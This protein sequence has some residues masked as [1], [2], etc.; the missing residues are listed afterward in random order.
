MHGRECCPELVQP[1]STPIQSGL[2][3]VYASALES[4]ECRACRFPSTTPQLA[5]RRVR[6]NNA[7]ITCSDANDSLIR[8]LGH[9]VERLSLVAIHFLNVRGCREDHYLPKERVSKK[10]GRIPAHLRRFEAKVE[11]PP[12]LEVIDALAETLPGLDSSGKRDIRNAVKD[13]RSKNCRPNCLMVLYLNR[14]AALD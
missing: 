14:G 9:P 8:I 1:E 5:D 7:G 12:W 13:V 4:C 2:F 11:G 6:T 10:T 3:R